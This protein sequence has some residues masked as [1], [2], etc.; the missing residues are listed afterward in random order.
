MKRQRY[1]DKIEGRGGGG[2]M[3]LAFA[4]SGRVRGRGPMHYFYIYN[5]FKNVPV[6][7]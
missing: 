7:I 2:V 5:T 1:D 4:F 3:R 6:P